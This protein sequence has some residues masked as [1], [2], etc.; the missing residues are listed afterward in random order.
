MDIDQ[1]LFRIGS[2]PWTFRDL[3]NHLIVTGVTG[4]GKTSG[5]LDTVIHSL[6]HSGAG[7]LVCTVKARE[8]QHWIEMAER[9]GHRDRLIILRPNDSEWGFNYLEYMMNQAFSDVETL[10]EAFETLGQAANVGGSSNDA[11]KDAY[12]QQAANDLARHACNVLLA[13]TG[14][15][16]LRA[17]LKLINSAPRGLDRDKD[18]EWKEKSYLCEMLTIAHENEQKSQ[19]VVDAFNYFFYNYALIPDETLG[20]IQSNLTSSLSAFSQ[21]RLERAFCGDRCNFLPELSRQGKILLLDFPETQ[22]G[23]MG[24]MVQRLYREVWF[25]AM[26]KTEVNEYTKPTFC[27]ADELQGLVRLDDVERLAIIRDQRIAM[28]AATQS[29]S[30]L[31]IPTALADMN[32]VRSM[33]INFGTKIY[34]STSCPETSKFFADGVG[35]HWVPHESKT[36]GSSINPETGKPQV[37][38]NT[39]ISLVERY[40][41]EPSELQR[42]KNG[43]PK[44]NFKVEAFVTKA[45]ENAMPQNYMKA[46]FTQ[47]GA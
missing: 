31:A 1:E 45:F 12:W 7:G 3:F 44:H 19:R 20:C 34:C 22:H 15:V 43:S 13:A 9:M 25:G 14:A 17:M 5:P 26:L 23:A 35:K 18:K 6:L 21:G 42:L 46:T 16:S 30:G 11:H 39:Q 41:V 24:K 28:I 8:T 37:T 33:Y 2:I 36:T 29:M 47:Y 32:I 38:E 10:I 4:S 27:Y 40:I